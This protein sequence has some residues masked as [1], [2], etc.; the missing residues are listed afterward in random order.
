MKHV[1]APAVAASIVLLGIFLASCATSSG[2]TYSRAASS[3]SGA[4][5]EGG[6]G[7]PR[8]PANRP[9]ANRPSEGRG[10]SA[11]IIV[12]EPRYEPKGRLAIEGLDGSATIF[13]DGLPR[14]GSR[15]ELPIG[16]H[17]VRISRFGFYDFEATVY[18]ALND[19]TR[20]Y[21]DLVPAGFSITEMIAEDEAF[22]PRDPGFLGSCR[23]RIGTTASGEGSFA[24]LDA[25]G[26]RV[27]SLGA[28]EFRG[29]RT[30]VSWD[31]RDDSGRF[32]DPGAYDIVA[33]G[34]GRG[35]EDRDSIRVE[36]VPGRFSRSASLHGGVSGALFSPDARCIEPGGFESVT[37]AV[38]HVEPEAGAM[39]GMGTVETGIRIGLSRQP[40]ALE[41]DASVMGVLWAADPLADS[42]SW[43]AAI[44]GSTASPDGRRA[45]GLYLRATGAS[46]TSPGS[47]DAVPSW[48]G[49]ARYP[50]LALGAPLEIAFERSRL[51]VAPEVE[52][53]EYYPYWYGS[54]P[55][56]A[57]PGL[58]AWGYLRA[59]IEAS[60]GR[61]MTLV[62]SGALRTEPFGS[63]PG[64]RWPLPLGLEARWHAPRMPLTL[65]FAVTGEI[66]SP[67]AYYF[68][69]GAFASLRL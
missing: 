15:F 33:E 27:R 21:A 60:V 51:F 38:F 40:A 23:I 28:A 65:S 35:S 68:G 55:H 44:K 10:S 8:P 9:P 32:L 6:G 41:L 11:V 53:S 63:A 12:N 20:L 7:S 48:D 50:G 13:V 4:A 22:D 17:E 47:G 58:F 29:P 19:E 36:I 5:R 24:V 59:G 42:V 16:R 30:L 3:E 14:L 34:R 62:A 25:S 31:G 69:A 2:G 18:I 67:F 64:I 46:F 56:Y 57:T 45:A 1:R 54:S 43:S 66:D 39:S 26:G 61:S 49:A 37:G 52:V